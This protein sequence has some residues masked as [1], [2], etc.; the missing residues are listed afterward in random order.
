L[1]PGQSPDLYIIYSVQTQEKMRSVTTMEGYGWG[2]GPWVGFGGWGGLE[3]GAEG[4]PP[5]VTDMTEQPRTM[6]ILTV[7]IVDAKKKQIV[8]RGQATVDHMSKSDNRD[9]S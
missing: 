9:Q 5:V 2:E 8:W 7:D 4:L 3:N 1:Y 6:G